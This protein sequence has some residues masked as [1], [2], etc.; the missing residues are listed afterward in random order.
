[1]EAFSYSLSVN[2]CICNFQSI[3]SE[4]NSLCIDYD[5]TQWRESRVTCHVSV[6]NTE[7]IKFI[8]YVELKLTSF[9]LTLEKCKRKSQNNYKILTLPTEGIVRLFTK[10]QGNSQESLYAC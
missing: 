3:F 8:I 7:R 6:K 2:I 1:M 9:P 5:R 10:K 4:K